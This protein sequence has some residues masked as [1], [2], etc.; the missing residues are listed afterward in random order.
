MSYDRWIA[1]RKAMAI[2]L[3]HAES[4]ACAGCSDLRQL[5]A[6]SR[7]ESEGALGEGER[8]DE[9]GPRNLLALV[10]DALNLVSSGVQIGTLTRIPTV[11]VQTITL[12]L[13]CIQRELRRAALTRS[14]PATPSEGRMDEIAGQGVTREVFGPMDA[15]MAAGRN[16]YYAHN[17]MASLITPWEDLHRIVQ[18]GW[19]LAA[20]DFETGND[21]AWRAP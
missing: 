2:C 19:A 21:A 17:A 11:D 1:T 7:P 13:V 20:H 9:N 5:L 14:S 3:K 6:A 4:C 16:L 8:V 15:W 10:A 12:N 18:S